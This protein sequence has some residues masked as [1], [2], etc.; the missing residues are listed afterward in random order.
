MMASIFDLHI[1]LKKP[2]EADKTYKQIK[3]S[4]PGFLLDEHK[5]IDYTTLLVECDQLQQAKIILTDRAKESKVRGGNNIQKNLWNLLS[6]VASKSIPGTNNETKEFFNFLVD[7]TFCSTQTNTL[8]GPIIREYLNKG[9][10]KEGILEYIDIC[11]K[12][13]KTPLQLELIKLC[14]SINE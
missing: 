12:Y 1:R 8:F 14:T 3:K 13:R 11:K 7:L 9:Q 4:F 2:T 10:L 6:M 5:I